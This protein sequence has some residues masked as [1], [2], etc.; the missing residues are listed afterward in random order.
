[1][2]MQV[3]GSISSGTPATCALAVPARLMAMAQAAP[4]I[5][6]IIRTLSLVWQG[7][8]Q[9]GGR[10]AIARR[11]GGSVGLFLHRDPEIADA[12]VLCLRELARADIDLDRGQQQPGHRQRGIARLAHGDE[13]LLADPV[14][15]MH[16]GAPL[17]FHRGFPA[18]LVPPRRLVIVAQEQPGLSRQREQLADRT[19]ERAGV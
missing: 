1:S 5:S 15:H 6:R 3:P 18:V 14:M 4:L 17:L 2:R 11:G 9:T 16:A 12:V 13:F 8:N 19:V 10:L 7:V